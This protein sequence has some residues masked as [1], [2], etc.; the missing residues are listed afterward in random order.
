MILMAATDALRVELCLDTW[1]WVWAGPRTKICGIHNPTCRRSSSHVIRP[2]A[3]IFSQHVS[4]QL[5]LFFLAVSFLLPISLWPLLVQQF[6][7]GCLLL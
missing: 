7:Q 2:C 1:A 6:T 3:G 4:L 5:V